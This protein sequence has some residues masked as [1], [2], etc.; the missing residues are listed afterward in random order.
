MPLK[1]DTTTLNDVVP[2]AL[3]WCIHVYGSIC[4]RQL[5]KAQDTGNCL[6]LGKGKKEN[7]CGREKTYLLSTLP[8]VC[9]LRYT[10]DLT[11]QAWQD[12]FF[13]FFGNYTRP[14][15]SIFSILKWSYTKSLHLHL[16]FNRIMA[17]QVY[18]KCQLAKENRKPYFVAASIM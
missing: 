17:K 13:L 1:K 9:S 8:A 18:I 2:F 10:H 16:H 3:G 4:M 7:G 6:P 5:I 15:Q 12:G 14:G 11:N